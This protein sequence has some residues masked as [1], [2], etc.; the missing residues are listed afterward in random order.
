VRAET[1]KRLRRRALLLAGPWCWAC[2]LLSETSARAPI[3]GVERSHPTAPA[4]REPADAT[5]GPADSHEADADD[6]AEEAAADIAGWLPDHWHAWGP[7][8]AECLYTGEAFDKL[9]GGI[10]NTDN[11]ARYRGNLDVTLT[12]DT[13]AADWWDGGEVFV[14][15][16]H[17][18]GTTLTPH[19]V[20]DGQYYS[21]IDTGPKAQDLTQLGEVYYKQNW[22]DAAWFKIGK[23]DA[24][25]DFAFAD[26]AGDFLNSSFATIPNVPL[27][28]WP[29]QTFGAAA[30]RQVD[31]TCRVGWRHLRP[32]A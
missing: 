10:P 6:A 19:F 5:T 28:F 9:R 8:T 32:G 13:A 2:L 17:A 21:N 23:Q 25:A 12:L 1:I 3:E 22:D 24:N 31:A 27:P 29:F 11:T 14:Y 7:L 20:G 30:S 15:L 26:L 4:L 16:Q 18:H